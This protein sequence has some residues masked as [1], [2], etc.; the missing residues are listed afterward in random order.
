MLL[1]VGTI[2]YDSI[3]FT[4]YHGYVFLFHYS[5][6][7]ILLHCVRMYTGSHVGKIVEERTCRDEIE[8]LEYLA[9]VALKRDD[10]A[11]VALKREDLKK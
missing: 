9:R 2:K 4:T 1:Q 11:R 8:R 6:L 5:T 3:Y 10:L 7:V